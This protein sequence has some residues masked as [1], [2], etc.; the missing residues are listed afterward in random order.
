MQ[1]AYKAELE[2]LTKIGIITEIKEHTEWINSIAPV[3]R[4]NGSLRLCLDPKDLKQLK[5]TNGI[6]GPLMT[7]YQSWPNQ[8]TKH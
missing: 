5:E 1:D 7:Y 3:M 8:S 6:Q 2:K 4:P